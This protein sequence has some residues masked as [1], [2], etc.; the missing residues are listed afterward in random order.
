MLKD[1]LMKEI[2]QSKFLNEMLQRRGQKLKEIMNIFES[3]IEF[4]ENICLK[5][6]DI[7]ELKKLIQTLTST[8]LNTS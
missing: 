3:R 4:Q 1:Q 2:E 5:D 7:I 6:G 8:V